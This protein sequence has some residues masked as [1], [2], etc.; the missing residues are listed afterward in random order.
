MIRSR[1]KYISVDDESDHNEHKRF[2]DEKQKI[3]RLDAKIEEIKK[4]H[5]NSNI[6]E[7]KIYSEKPSIPSVDEYDVAKN[8]I[9]SHLSLSTKEEK[10]EKDNM[11]EKIDKLIKEK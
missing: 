2:F 5:E 9:D 10:D 11:R 4:I 6:K 8:Y 7:T 3:D 1:R